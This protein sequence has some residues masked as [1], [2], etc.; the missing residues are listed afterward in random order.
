[1]HYKKIGVVIADTEEYSAFL[2]CIKDRAPK[3]FEYFD[4][5][6][7]TFRVNTTEVICLYSGVGKVNAA[8]ATM[9][10]I[11]LGAEAVLNFGLSGGLGENVRG[12]ITL[13][14]KFVE[15]DFDL[16]NIGYKLCQKPG[17]DY[18]IYSAD[19]EIVSVFKT[20]YPQLFGGTAVSGDSFICDSAVSK[21]LF[22]TFGADSCDMET[23]AV[24]AVCRMANI[25]FCALRR[26]SDDAGDEAIEIYR[27][28]NTGDGDVLC[29]VFLNCL[30]R[31]CEN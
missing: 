2:D 6:G 12:G 29:R 17:Q 27:E 21:K 5:L 4:R 3:D 1:M 26:I 16:S 19:K 14:E 11:D 30:D 7:V 10:L 13:P 23:A 8:A 18:Y 22:D 15:H 24:A 20:V 25:P 28:M 31:L 9:F